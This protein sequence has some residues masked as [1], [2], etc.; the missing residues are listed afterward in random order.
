MNLVL[1]TKILFALA[2]S[3]AVLLFVA[4]S[5]KRNDFDSK[6][7]TL[8]SFSMKGDTMSQAEERILLQ[9]KPSTKIDSRRSEEI[10]QE[11]EELSFS[12]RELAS[13]LVSQAIV[14]P[15]KDVVRADMEDILRFQL[16][17]YRCQNPS[18]CSQKRQHHFRGWSAGLGAQLQV[19]G[20]SF[21]R[22]L[23]NQHVFILDYH[24]SKY[25]DPRRCSDQSYK[26]LF[27]PITTCKATDF[28]LPIGAKPQELAATTCTMFDPKL[29]SKQAGLSRVYSVEWYFREALRYLTRPNRELKQFGQSV[30]FEMG[31]DDLAGKKGVGVKIRAGKDK[32]TEVKR[33]S[34]RK[35]VDIQAA[36]GIDWENVVN[37]FCESEGGANCDY[38]FLSTDT[39]NE[40][41]TEKLH[42]ALTIDV[43]TMKSTYFVE[44]NL[45]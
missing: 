37:D 29:F 17:I 23:L 11:L 5:L 10:S 25:I 28:A 18:D 3:S 4:F 1:F 27:L 39:N 14:S 20:N 15:T 26:C 9:K 41:M 16:W 42:K 21:L 12:D 32:D 30:R 13:L 38:V 31:L 45:R 6:S 40:V 33:I 35:C 7:A 2:L 22:A 24:K 8:A 36:D 43:I 44:Q 34:S 19:I